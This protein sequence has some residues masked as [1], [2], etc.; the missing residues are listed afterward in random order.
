MSP[1]PAPLVELALS[2]PPTL[3]STRLVCLDGP[4]GSG[5]TTLADL[6]VADCA[7]RGLSTSLVHMDDVYEGWSGL[8]AAGEKVRT[9]IVEPL[10]RGEAAGYHRYDW[11]AQEY[12][13][14]VPVAPADLLVVEGVGSGH[15]GY[16]DRI[17]VL[18]FVEAPQAT[19]FR[20]GLERDGAALAPQW[21]RW[22]LDEERLHE[23]E[24][25]RARADVLVD[26]VTGRLSWPG[27]RWP[28]A[29]WPRAR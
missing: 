11:H 14:L 9:T 23:A 27:A 16:A 22:A 13:E 28:G 8:A 20:R 26:G 24:Q 3:R 12:A 4:A 21:R 25:T 2:R 5:K 19:R 10:G 7:R 1:D 18:A 29:R 15:L 17:T 6:L